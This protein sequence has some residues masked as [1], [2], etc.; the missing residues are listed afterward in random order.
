MRLRGR[1]RV[2]KAKRFRKILSSFHTPVLNIFAPRGLLDRQFRACYSF[3]F[4]M[5]AIFA[6]YVT[7]AIFI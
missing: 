6:L 4:E 3:Y 1:K 5:R 2:F 7:K